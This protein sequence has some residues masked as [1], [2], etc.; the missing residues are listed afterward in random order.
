MTECEGRLSTRLIASVIGACLVGLTGCEWLFE[1]SP[2]ASWKRA[3]AA[4]ADRDYGR[5][6]DNLSTASKQDTI[7]V[8]N[9]VKLNPKYR[10]IMRDKF[11]IPPDMIDTI[12]PR[13]F[14]IALMTGVERT[15][16]Q[17]IALRAHAAKTAKFSH[18]EVR[19]NKAVV[20][21]TSPSAGD[22]KMAFI[23]EDE[24]WKPIIER[25]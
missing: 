21:W 7:K 11:Q 19:G 23:L 13:N 15:A 12:D 14:F 24:R 5:L 6:W 9:H 1:D 17:M 4:Y 3:M 8:L 18:Q 25:R 10:Q 20:Y 16:P 2:K 22:E